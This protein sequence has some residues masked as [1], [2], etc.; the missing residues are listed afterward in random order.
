MDNTQ[1]HVAI[2]SSPGMGHLI[3]V[4]VLGNL[5]A[6]HHN[7]KITI[8][9]ITSSSSSETEFL[10]KSNEKK[11]IEIIPIPSVDMTHLIDSTTKVFTQIRLLVR[12]ALPGIRSVI[13][14]MN[15]RPYALIVDIYCTQMWPIVE[16]F[17]IPKYV[18]HLTTAWLLA[19]FIYQQVLDQEIQGE[20]VDLKQPLEIPGCKAL[21]PDDVLDPMMDRSNQ[22]Y[23]EYLKLAME[24]TCFDGIL[25]NTWEDFEGETIQAL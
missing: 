6:T 16:E 4:L 14:S 13:A 23:Q 7:I 5:L 21:Q 11:T 22:R 25:I 1:L 18:F 2:V 19:V 8:L 24:Y 10:K 15:H 9:A 12:E 17:N 3:P 20:Y